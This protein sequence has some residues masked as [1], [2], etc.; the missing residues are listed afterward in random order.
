MGASDCVAGPV[1]VVDGA[2]DG[3]EEAA[4]GARGRAMGIF[5]LK[6]MPPFFLNMELMMTVLL[7]VL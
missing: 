6:A 2:L 1:A 4:P 5:G 3:W 7:K